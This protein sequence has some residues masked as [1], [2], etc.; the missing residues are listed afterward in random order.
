MGSYGQ[1]S[2]NN[3]KREQTLTGPYHFTEL[4]FDMKE[5]VWKAMQ[6]SNHKNWN[7]LRF[8]FT[9][10]KGESRKGSKCYLIKETN[11]T[12]VLWHNHILSL[13]VWQSGICCKPFHISSH[14]LV[15][16]IRITPVARLFVVNII[17]GNW[18]LVNQYV[19]YTYPIYK[20]A[21]WAMNF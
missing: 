15:Y 16:I 2:G 8:P 17:P 14:R 21:S 3:L 10:T 1:L 19:R 9:D 12:L 4:S 13:N 11:R 7:V 20:Q 18:F 5:W 6:C